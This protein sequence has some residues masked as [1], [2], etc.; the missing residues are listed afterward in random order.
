MAR[1]LTPR[2][3]HALMNQ[4]VVEAT[5]QA[6]INVVDSS[7]FVSAGELVLSTGV[8]N[9][10]NALSIVMGRTF[11]AV[12]PYKAKLQIINALNTDLYTNRMRKISF[13][14]RPALASGDFNTQL[15]K[16]LADGFDNGS[17]P[18]N[19]TPQSTASM[20]Q[21]NQPE[22]LEMNFGGT[23]T[24]EDSTTIYEYQLKTA[25]RSEEEFGQ[26]VSGIM[27]E[28]ANDIESQKEAFNRMTIL[29][30]IAGIYDMDTA[31]TKINL[32]AAF[33]A[34]YGTSYTS[35]QLRNEHA[36]EFL[37]FFVALFKIT[38]DYMT[39]RS[40]N[41]HWSPTKTNAAGESL[42][43]LRHTPKEKQRFLYYSPLF[44]EAKTKVFPEIF[45]PQY[46][47]MEAGEGVTYWQS[48]NSPT[49]IKVT[50]AIPDKSTGVQTA[51]DT[52]ELDYVVGVL[53]DVD[54]LMIDYQLEAAAT[55]PLEARKHFRNMWWSFA[56][57]SINDF[58]ENGIIFYMS[59]T[60]PVVSNDRA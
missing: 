22:V 13:Y 53:Y 28:K 34:K 57:N 15:Y 30:Y 5:G 14:S 56:K 12:R 45:N 2:D 38:S 20:W 41:Y 44:T 51:G 24:W 9:V 39:N 32:T 60:S 16:N 33:N 42:V 31:G 54:A 18:N 58:T 6:S 47:N 3:I 23:S 40:A 43:L 27:T 19:G 37:E 26:F 59:D 55:T 50:P 21:Q 11:M 46:L 48:I 1:S 35:A 49:A 10:L 4:L 7:T 25:F 17:N 29:N 52:V 36:T 8:E